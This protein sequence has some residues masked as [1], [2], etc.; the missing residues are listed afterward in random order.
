MVA[1]T[2]SCEPHGH[3]QPFGSYTGPTRQ[4]GMPS[5]LPPH[6]PIFA[7]ASR[8]KT[9]FCK[10]IALVTLTATPDKLCSSKSSRVSYNVVTQVVVTLEITIARNL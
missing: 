4:V 8:K 1:A 10:T 6:P 9:T 2:T 7:A 5:M 3:G